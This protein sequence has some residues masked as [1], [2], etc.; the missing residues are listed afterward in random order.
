[1][2]PPYGELRPTSGWDR[3]TSLGYP[4]KFQLVS[5]LGS[6]TARHLLVGVSQTLRRWT[7]GATYIRQGDHHVGHWPTFIVIHVCLLIESESETSSNKFSTEDGS[8][9]C[10]ITFLECLLCVIIAQLSRARYSFCLS[11][12][13]SGTRSAT[14]P[15]TKQ[16]TLR[17]RLETLVLLLS[18][19][20]LKFQWGHRQR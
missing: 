19:T 6:V 1:M 10:A 7:E 3:L 5:H 16:W 12:C 17:S 4:C 13:P 8:A 18:K 11:V 14:E 20:F 9:F 15:I 2:S